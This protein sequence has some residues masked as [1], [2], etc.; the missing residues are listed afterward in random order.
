MSLSHEN[1][2]DKNAELKPLQTLFMPSGIVNANM[3]LNH[4]ILI[5]VL[6]LGRVN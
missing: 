3:K 4:G 1:I 6:K 5:I 2:S